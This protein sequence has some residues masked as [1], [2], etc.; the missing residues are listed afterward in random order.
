[1]T[2]TDIAA[3]EK[4]PRPPVVVITGPTASGKSGLALALAERLD[5]TII[6][7]DSMQIYAELSVVT[8]RPTA[9]EEARVPHRLFGVLPAAERCSA[10]RWLTLAQGAVQ[11]AWAAGR[12]PL[13]VGGTG[14]YLK[15]LM[16]GLAPVP[17]VPEEVRAEAEALLDALGGE[18][19]RTR[20]AELDPL[21]AARLPAGDRQRL[22][23]AYG[24]AR[25][26]GRT[27][28]DWQAG[29][30]TGSALAA[31]FL[32]ILIQPPRDVL[33]AACDARFDAM[34]AA[35]AEAEV[36]ALMA[37]D[38]D[39][40]LPALRAVGVRELAACLRGEVDLAAAADKA[41]QATRNFAKRQ[42]TWF[43]HQLSPDLTL[44]EGG[45]A[46]LT[47]SL[48]FFENAD[49]SGRVQK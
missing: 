19:F 45:L 5:G 22:V 42:M 14:M 39:P 35:G 37:L 9:A 34:L 41:R 30:G 44:T 10:G 13:V 27:L 6:N 1:M 26:T 3:P 49:L 2:V 36:R 31:R 8:A 23:R 28:A 16:Q 18:A 43:R 32:T 15:S 33:Y 12:L 47:P 17:E 4:P 11:E 46:A 29:A 38:L 20:L 24:V 48:A 7:A 21:A 25:A 40:S